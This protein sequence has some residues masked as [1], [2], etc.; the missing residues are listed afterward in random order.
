M[1]KIIDAENSDLFDVLA[2]V[3]FALQPISR[4]ERAAR[5]IAIINANFNSKQQSF[6][7]FVLS[8]YVKVGVEELDQEKLTPLLRLRCLTSFE[9]ERRIV[10]RISGASILRR[11]SLIQIFLKAGKYLANILRPAEIGHGI[12][13]CVV[14]SQL[15]Q[16]SEFFL[17]E[18]PDAD[19][20]VMRE[21]E[22]E[23]HPLP[24]VEVRADLHLRLRR[25]I[26]A[27]ERRQRVGDMREHV[28]E[29]P[30]RCARACGLRASAAHARRSRGEGEGG[31]QHAL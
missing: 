8:H 18:F 16:R 28:E 4:E 1:Q 22:V 24:A 21:H 25:A 15:E 2:H 13:D 19:A 17:V 5:A 7:D 10:R 14:V 27:R 9:I 3:S 11:S 6:L 31:N 20:H 23:K 26:F 30:L 12:G 29:R